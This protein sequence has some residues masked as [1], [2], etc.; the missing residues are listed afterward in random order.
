MSDSGFPEN[1]T[2]SSLAG[3][4]DVNEDRRLSTDPAMRTITGKKPKEKDGNLTLREIIILFQ[5]DEYFNL[6]LRL[7]IVIYQPFHI[8]IWAASFIIGIPVNQ[9]NRQH[10][11]GH[12]E[13]AL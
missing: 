2:F 11:R 10:Q 7:T 3:Y 5:G 4:E 12:H 9:L 6:N 8:L 13:T 1:C